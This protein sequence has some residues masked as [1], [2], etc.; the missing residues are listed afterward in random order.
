M[1]DL[2]SEQHML[3]Q[4]PGL[5]DLAASNCRLIR[6]QLKRLFDEL[7]RHDNPRAAAGL[8]LTDC[9]EVLDR[10]FQSFE[11]QRETLAD[12]MSSLESRAGATLRDQPAATYLQLYR[13]AITEGD[14][15]AASPWFDRYFDSV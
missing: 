5:C 10:L 15:A 7:V 4:L 11:A 8:S 13:A 2:H 9:R 14:F 12:L 1:V 3:L 6:A